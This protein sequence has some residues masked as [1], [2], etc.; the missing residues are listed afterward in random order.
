MISVS[1]NPADC[2]HGN[3]N[4][5]SVNRLS[6]TFLLPLQTKYQPKTLKS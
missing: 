6:I 1:H 5:F 2:P 4:I 3:K